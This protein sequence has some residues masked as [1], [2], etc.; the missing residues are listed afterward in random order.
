M[1]AEQ[2]KDPWIA[3]MISFLSG[4]A[5]RW[6]RSPLPELLNRI[7]F[8]PG[9]SSELTQTALAAEEEQTA[10]D[11][12]N[13]GYA[14]LPA[15]AHRA[16]RR[17]RRAAG[18]DGRSFFVVPVSSPLPTGSLGQANTHEGLTDF[19]HGSRPAPPPPSPFPDPCVLSNCTC[20]FT[21]TCTTLLARQRPF[22][23]L[24]G[25][26]LDPAFDRLLPIRVPAT[27][28]Q[29]GAVIETT[30]MPFESSYMAAPVLKSLN[31]VCN[32]PPPIYA[33]RSPSWRTVP[34]PS[35]HGCRSSRAVRGC[36]CLGIKPC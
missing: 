15:C 31:P 13:K 20:S 4:A 16:Q 23:F 27:A 21:Q 29:D 30:R 14:I 1:C 2:R 26:I 36:A 9:S 19:L 10:D 33:S 11:R 32:R 7:S 18:G 12:K 35:L 3:S 17:W 24:S 6:L 8:A 34:S 25:V 22:P 28:E 5:P